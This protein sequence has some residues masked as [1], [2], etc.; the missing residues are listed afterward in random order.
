MARRKLKAKAVE[1][2]RVSKSRS[3]SDLLKA[4][5]KTGFQGRSLALCA[6][7]LEKMFRDRKTTV[8]L[9][10]AGSL[11]TTG[12]YEIINWFIE[13]GYVDILVATGANLS[14]DLVDAMGHPYIQGTH[15]ADDQALFERGYNRYYDVYGDEAHYM[16]MT[17]LISR[18]MLELES[19]QAY[20]SRQFLNK[21]GL[22]LGKK[23]RSIVSVAARHQVPVFCPAIID[24]PYGDAALIAKSKGFN[25]VS[26]L[27]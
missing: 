23:N 14:E 24:S 11:S 2:I 19:D 26:T 5:G 9:G 15:K 21:F 12:Q 3:V 25:L 16:C 7:T 17:E 20:S 13:N 18:F 10:Y 8:L 22:W 27:R 4:M 1:Q 6:D